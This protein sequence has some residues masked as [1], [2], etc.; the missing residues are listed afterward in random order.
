MQP[1]SQEDL[2]G[3]RYPAP[4]RMPRKTVGYGCAVHGCFKRFKVNKSEVDA[5][6]S[7]SDGEEDEETL[8]KRLFPRTFHRYCYSF[9]HQRKK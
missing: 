6:R 5:E 8:L 1:F 3:P 7:E 9:S 4:L 2:Q